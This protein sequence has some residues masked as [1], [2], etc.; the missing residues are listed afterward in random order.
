MGLLFKFCTARLILI[1]S[2]PHNRLWKTV[3]VY[4]VTRN[5]EIHKT[6]FAP[7]QKLMAHSLTSNNALGFFL[8]GIL[9][10]F[11]QKTSP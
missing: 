6:P 10:H 3:L 11:L 8:K 5:L 7:Q 4:K 9:K 1:S 2:S